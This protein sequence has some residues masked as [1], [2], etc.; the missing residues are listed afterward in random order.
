MQLNKLLTLLA[1][2]LLTNLEST[3]QS[4]NV[5]RFDEDY[6]YLIDSSR[7]FYNRIK[8]CP[9]SGDKRVYLSVGGEMRFE[10]AAFDN[11]DWGLHDIGHDNFFL[12]RYDL[13]AD[14]HISKRLRFFGQ[15]RSALENGRKV[16]PR[17]IDED[18]LNI[19]NLFVDFT[20]LQD[21][22]H[23]LI[24]R[25]GRQELD[26]GSGR[27]ISVREGPNLRLYFTGFKVKY[28]AQNFWAD[29]FVMMADNV[30]PGIFDNTGTGEANL[31]GIYSQRT[32][33]I[34]N[35]DL[36]YIGIRRDSSA[37]EEGI[38]KEIRHTLGGRLW[39]S[40]NGFIYNI[41]TAYQFGTFGRGNIS[42]WTGSIDAGYSFAKAKLSPVIGIRNDY[43]SGD[44]KAG[45]GSLQTFNPIYPRGGYFG[46][47]PQIGPENLIDIHPYIILNIKQNLFCQA[48]AVFNWRYS[49]QD[50]IY[51]PG[52]TIKLEDVGNTQRYIGTSW[53]VSLGYNIN[54]FITF[55][56]GTQYFKTGS[57]ID[58]AIPD[59]KDGLFTNIRLGFK[60]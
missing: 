46:F 50:G 11:E 17:P 60:F 33:K 52:G 14:L 59:H 32:F 38:E 58:A 25:A 9:L 24:L 51:T 3:G 23:T 35:L 19:Q 49:L 42:A 13:H 29:A 28:N 7:T 27:L 43:I 57:F 44:K 21:S 18:K 36:Y 15:L 30:R 40:G 1:T 39:R 26:Y 56:I 37:F 53:L 6:S 47:D 54:K 2:I 10:Y 22:G 12:Q 8:Y 31:W 34:N 16:G 45:D 41:E 4:F 20:A 48:D 5:M 55:D